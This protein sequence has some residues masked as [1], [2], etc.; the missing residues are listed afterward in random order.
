MFGWALVIIIAVWL[1]VKNS[2]N[3]AHSDVSPTS[4]EEKDISE[5]T[6]YKMQ[7]SF[8]K[9]LEQ[10]HLPDSPGGRA[11]YMYRNLVCNWFYKLA[12]ENRY[13]DEMTQ[14]L[15]RDFLEY[16]YSVEHGSTANYLSLE[17]EDKESQDE[18]EEEART[19]ARK[20][21]TIENAFAAAVGKEAENELK[22][23]REL[24]YSAISREG[25]LAPDGYKY[26]LLGELKP[27]KR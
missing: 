27:I 1:I 17:V 2:K 15:R 21:Y 6:V 7:N 10:N 23:V 25:Q 4:V 8:E 14:K 12:A 5:E 16:I 24:D 13:N 22:R 11:I 19:Q 9:R 18:H 3:S 20:I 26:D